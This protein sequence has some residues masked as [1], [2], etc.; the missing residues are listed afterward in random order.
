MDKTLVVI[1][2]DGVRKGL[3]G[4]IINRFERRHIDIEVIEFTK[5]KKE[6][7]QELYS[8]HEGKPFYDDL[9]DFIVSGP[10]VLMVL[11]GEEVIPVIR[12]MMGATDPKEADPGTIRGDFALDISQNIIH[13]SDSEQS[14][15]RE[16]AIF[17]P[18]LV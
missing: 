11:K 10:I 3:V 18:E 6:K 13:G 9:V 2:P 5:L 12:K 7:A 8:V 16:I 4:E 15:N 17:F 14:A 1:K